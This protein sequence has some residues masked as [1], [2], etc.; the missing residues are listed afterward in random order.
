MVGPLLAL[1]LAAQPAE[2]GRLPPA[3]RELFRIAWQRDLAGK[4]LGE[5]RPLELGG[6]AHDPVTRLV[7][8]GTRD[9]WLHAVRHDGTVAWDFA[10]GGAFAGEPLI[11]GD[12]VYAGCNDGRLYAVGLTTGKE[13]WRYEAREALGTRPA[14]VDGLVVVASRQDTVYAVDARTGAWRWHHRRESGKEGFTVQGAA[15]VVAGG[16]L[17]HAGFSDG[18]LLAL[19]AATGQVRWERHAAPRG[20]YPDVDSL[21]L[22]GGRLFAAA[23]SGAVVAV[24]AATGKPAWQAEIPEAARVAVVPGAL[25]VVS[26][27]SVQALSTADGR[28]LWT[29]PLAGSPAGEPRLA[30]GRWLLVPAGEGG[31]RFLEPSTGRLVRVLDP[32]T[33]VSA[34]PALDGRSAW[35][36][37]NGGRLLSIAFE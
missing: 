27:K 14:L 18:T 30:A 15:S 4:T 33:G 2:A 17:V 29:A 9:G 16:G 23:F 36:L 3:P 24:E 37:S 11:D 28:V 25:L 13:R 32:G 6:A 5:V 10:G 31:L 26:T 7:V 19:D 1:A 34:S 8:V 35:V 21:A 20:E 22:S 12:T